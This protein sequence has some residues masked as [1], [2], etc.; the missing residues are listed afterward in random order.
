VPVITALRE[1]GRGRVAVDL[2]GEHWR[3]IP[4]DVAVRAGLTEG[5]AL[6][7]PALRLLRRELRRAEALAVA[8]RA[9]R[10][11]DLSTRRLEERLQRGAVA[12]AARAESVAVLARAGL[13]DDARFAA[14]RAEA[15][16]G[17]GYGDLAIRHDLERQGIAAEAISAVLAGLEP[18]AERARRVVA[19]RGTGSRTARYLAA[20]G[21]GEEAVE[22]A[23]GADFANDP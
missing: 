13:V 23:S 11:R 10:H 17:R 20:K 14:G 6:D 18:E 21:F 15:L 3:I 8:G 16:A 19:R 9:L 7:R 1:D 2:D 12:P 22:A 5:R 4:V